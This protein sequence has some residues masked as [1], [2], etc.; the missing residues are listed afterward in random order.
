M[1]EAHPDIAQAP[2]RAHLASYEPVISPRLLGCE[3][4]RHL[5]V[6][7]LWKFSLLCRVNADVTVSGVKLEKWE[8][9]KKTKNMVPVVSSGWYPEFIFHIKTKWKMVWTFLIEMHSLLKVVIKIMYEKS[10]CL[11][12]TCLV[13]VQFYVWSQHFKN[14]SEDCSSLEKT[15]CQ[16]CKKKRERSQH[17]VRCRL[18]GC[19]KCL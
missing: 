12:Y 8:F 5:A 18:R 14:T 4:L 7:W 6:V 9:K 2:A 11:I 15:V 13:S 19:N 1:E 17:I 10:K 16:F 3:S